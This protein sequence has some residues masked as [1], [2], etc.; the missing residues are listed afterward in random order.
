MRQGR[1]PSTGQDEKV[2]GY[3]DRKLVPSKPTRVKPVG[4]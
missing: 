4:R 1:R 3:P 2:S